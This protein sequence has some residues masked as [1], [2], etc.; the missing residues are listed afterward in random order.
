MF[1]HQVKNL[2][3]RWV[4]QTRLT[5]AFQTRTSV[6]EFSFR[7]QQRGENSGKMFS[8]SSEISYSE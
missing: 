3:E 5:A 7:T 2:G 8:I 4:T 6:S 1:L